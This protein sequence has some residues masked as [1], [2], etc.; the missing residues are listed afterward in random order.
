MYERTRFR[1]FNV[2][3]QAGVSLKLS[4]IPVQIS[5]THNSKYKILN[6]IKFCTCTDSIA[7]GA[8]AHFHGDQTS[9]IQIKAY[10]NLYYE[11]MGEEC[12]VKQDLVTRMD[13]IS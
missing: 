13:G 3:A 9:N 6:N 5:F 8:C 2:D 11:R 10:T 4:K 12:L 7:V 1:Y